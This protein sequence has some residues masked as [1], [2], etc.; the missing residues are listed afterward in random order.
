VEKT[1]LTSVGMFSASLYVGTMME[2]GSWGMTADCNILAAARIKI[3]GANHGQ[4]SV[5]EQKE[6][7]V[8]RPA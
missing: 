6:G 8:D 5:A 1:R 3:A 7:A 4:R 2:T